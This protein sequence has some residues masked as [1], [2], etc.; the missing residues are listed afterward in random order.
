MQE[1]ILQQES[2]R[3]KT[4]NPKIQINA[5]S[6]SQAPEAAASSEAKNEQMNVNK[7]DTVL[8]KPA[9]QPNLSMPAF[10][11]PFK[12]DSTDVPDTPGGMLLYSQLKTP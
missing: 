7:I 12:K 10:D 2:E 6:M 4:H 1:V 9:L 3:K 8:L 5:V 11:T